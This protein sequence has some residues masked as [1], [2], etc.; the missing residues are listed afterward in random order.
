MWQIIENKNWS[1]IYNTFDWIRDMENVPQDA[2]YH[3]EGNVAI[4]TR[5][6]METLLELSEYQYLEQKEQE[7]LFAAALMH[8][9]EKRSTT[10]HEPDGRISSKGHAKKGAYTSR[11]LLY[12]A[13]KTPFVIKEQI[14]KLVRYHGLPLWI[15]EK[16]EPLK[17]LFKASLEVNI[18]LLYILAKADA[19][20]RVCDDQ[21]QLLY[22]LELFKE[23]ALEQGC[24]D[25]AKVF[26]SEFGRYQYF[27]KPDI[28]PTYIPFEANCFEVILLSA[29][30]GSGKDYFIK[31][32]YPDWPVVSID[33]LRRKHKIGP[34]DK[35][36]NGQM[37]Q[38]AKA[39]AKSYLRK[40][41]SFIWNATN[42]TQNMRLQLIDL[43]QTYG[44]KT[45]VIYIEVPFERL[46]SQN[47]NRNNPVPLKVLLKMIRK[48]EP[49]APWEA[50]VVEWLV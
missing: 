15:F 46:M 14:A 39:L 7:I 18:A 28:T 27:S 10:V 38:T 34:K 16:P 13:Y 19:I 25:Q 12:Q 1:S 21:G 42:I 36:G 30:P 45:K 44:A 17:S 43:F 48:L 32:N 29:L 5:M 40:K 23:L 26:G 49:P 4:H 20:G 47:K 35:K 3:Q 8:D 33:A 2:I 6:V 22:Q 41:R 9:I 24:F 11:S 37:I 50:S 31:K